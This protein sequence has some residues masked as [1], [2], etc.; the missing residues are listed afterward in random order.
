[1]PIVDFDFVKKLLGFFKKPTETTTERLHPVIEPIPP[2]PVTTQPVT[3]EEAVDL[4][5]A[6][7]GADTVEQPFFHMTGG[8][9]LRNGLGLWNKEGALHQHMLRRFGLCHADDTGM[10]ISHAAHAKVNDLPYDIDADI[11]RCKE[12]WRRQ[13]LDPAT[14]ERIGT[15]EPIT[16]FTISLQDGRQAVFYGNETPPSP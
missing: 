12:H 10:L 16:N 7:I 14:M 11:T 5:A 4:V 15:A 9:S 2:R 1:M 3:F 8:M 13:G 6:G